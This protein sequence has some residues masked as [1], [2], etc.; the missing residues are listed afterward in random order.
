MTL[1]EVKDDGTLEQVEW[2]DMTN[3]TATISDLHGLKHYVL[4]E[5][6]VPDGYCAYE[7]KDP[8]HAHSENE[9]YNDRE[10]HDYQGC[11]EEL[12]IC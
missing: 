8:V 1:Y 7:L 12:Q 11:A 3:P 5:T 9:A 4:V 2:F 10:P 6:E